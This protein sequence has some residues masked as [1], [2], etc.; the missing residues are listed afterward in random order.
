MSSA[1]GELDAAGIGADGQVEAQRREVTDA[2]R[3]R[4]EISSAGGPACR[5]R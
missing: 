2:R 1:R 4:F 5:A 3:E